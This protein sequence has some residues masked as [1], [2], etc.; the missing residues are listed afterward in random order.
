M[1]RGW[2]V[3]V[4]A[5]QALKVKVEASFP[6]GLTLGWR[7]GGPLAPAFP[8]LLSASLDPSPRARPA[9]GVSEQ[10]ARHC[11][12]CAASHPHNSPGRWAAVLPAGS[13]ALI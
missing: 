3:G 10:L 1:G 7:S 8:S 5:G 2:S 11:P 6:G 13:G 12:G 9:G 4:T